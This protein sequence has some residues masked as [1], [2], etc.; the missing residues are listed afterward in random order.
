M[1]PTP[2]IADLERAADVLAT[3]DDAGVRMVGQAI[4]T[5]LRGDEEQLEHALGFTAGRRS[6]G[7]MSALAR[8][9]AL[10]R[11]AAA[12]HLAHLGSAK[13]KADYFAHALSRYRTTTWPKHR[14]LSTCPQSIIGTLQEA[15]FQILTVLDRDIG[16]RQLRRIVEEGLAMS[17]VAMANDGA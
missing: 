17:S 14:T 15:C 1:K 11:Q 16:D 12:E 4:Q 13:A 10:I 5:W 8:R 9:D 6:I 3:F 2:A 7:T